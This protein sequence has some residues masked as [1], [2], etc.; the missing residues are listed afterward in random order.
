MCFTPLQL[1]KLKSLLSTKRKKINKNKKIMST[2]EEVR[3][4]IQKQIQMIDSLDIILTKEQQRVILKDVRQINRKLEEYAKLHA[5]NDAP[6]ITEP[7]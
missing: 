1:E 6:R 3:A 5:V 4:L 7:S 2:I